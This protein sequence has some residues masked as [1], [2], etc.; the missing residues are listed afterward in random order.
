M[1]IPIFRNRDDTGQ[2]LQLLRYW[3]NLEVRHQVDVSP[4]DNLM[5]QIKNVIREPDEHA[6]RAFVYVV[7]RERLN[8]GD[9]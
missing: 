3:M 7:C 2:Q 1:I 4:K 8:L 5:R 9:E 6:D